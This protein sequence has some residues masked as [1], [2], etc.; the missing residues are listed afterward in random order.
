M[1]STKVT[2]DVVPGTKAAVSFNVPDHKSGKLDVHYLHHH[3]AINSSI[4]LN[5]SPQLEV[6]A[7][8]FSKDIAI[9]GEVGFDT[10]SS[11]FTKFNAGIRFN[12]QDF[13]A[14]VLLY[15]TLVL[16]SLCTFSCL[17]GLTKGQTVKAS[18]AHVVNPLTGTEV[19]AEMTHRLSSFQNS[20]SLGS[21]H[22]IDSL[23]SMKT[24]FSDD[25]FSHVFSTI[26]QAFVSEYAVAGGEAG[27]GNLLKALAEAVTLFVN[28]ND[29]R[30][31]PDAIVFD[32]SKLQSP[33]SSLTASA[34]SWTDA[35]SGRSY[36]RVKV[37]NFGGNR[38]NLK[39]SVEGLD[40]KSIQ[41]AGSTLTT[42]TSTNVNDKN[43]FKKS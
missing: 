10:S 21:V 15:A 3:A 31:N 4:G 25:G 17:Q 6:S 19:A 40:N 22:K 16:I 14:A 32:S 13:S 42:L 9:G 23:T 18:Y 27:R 2:Y 7:A 11:F 29:Q 43:S 36:V 28:V 34:I 8:I 37:V 20:F 38:V 24:R 33:S 39:L 35:D 41:S 5:P 26:F 1:V 30:F 12:K